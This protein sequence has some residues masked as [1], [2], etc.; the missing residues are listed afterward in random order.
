MSSHTA[1]SQARSAKQP[2]TTN[3]DVLDELEAT[4]RTVIAAHDGYLGEAIRRVRW[5]RHGLLQR[6]RRAHRPLMAAGT[7]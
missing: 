5:E 3:P 4:T 7:A 2:G 6:L 1:F